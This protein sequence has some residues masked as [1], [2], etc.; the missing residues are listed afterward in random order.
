K[1]HT[2]N[3]VPLMLIDDRFRMRRTRKE[4]FEEAGNCAVR[5]LLADVAPTVVQLFGID[6]VKDMSG[7]SLLDAL[8]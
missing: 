2:S 5:G 6:D 4:K 7:M 1:E 3:P 8:E